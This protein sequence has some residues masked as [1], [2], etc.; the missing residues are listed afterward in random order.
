M[1]ESARRKR[2]DFIA[3]I[4]IK[5]VQNALAGNPLGKVVPSERVIQEK[6]LAPRSTKVINLEAGH[7]SIVNHYPL[8]RR[9]QVGT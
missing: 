4:T 9:W 1:A 3:P 5:K 8:S 6:L 7:V 2:S